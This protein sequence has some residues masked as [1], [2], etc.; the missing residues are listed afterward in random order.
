MDGA[1]GQYRDTSVAGVA[2]AFS[3]NSRNAF[4]TQN[5]T[6]GNQGEGIG[7]GANTGGTLLLTP[8]NYPIINL[9]NSSLPGG[10]ASSTPIL[11]LPP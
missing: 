1:N 5:V 2:G 6:L 3:S 9:K 8:G 7:G 10:A 11:D 4:T